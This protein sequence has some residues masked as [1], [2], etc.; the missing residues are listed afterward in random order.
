[1]SC[2]VFWENV[3]T[4]WGV[5]P[6]WGPVWGFSDFYVVKYLFWGAPGSVSCSSN[7]LVCGIL[8]LIQH[9][10]GWQGFDYFSGWYCLWGA[11]FWCVSCMGSYVSGTL[12][13]V[14]YRVKGCLIEVSAEG[15]SIFFFSPTFFDSFLFKSVL[16]RVWSPNLASFWWSFDHRKRHMIVHPMKILY[17]G[18]PHVSLLC[19]KSFESISSCGGLFIWKTIFFHFSRKFR[20]YLDEF[21]I[22]FS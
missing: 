14:S 7:F 8:C 18:A 21:E 17:I 10:K 12:P 19:T 22:P 15:T 9:V 5:L 2:G 13:R 4:F 11:T 3:R 20:K 1:M 16:N 6:V